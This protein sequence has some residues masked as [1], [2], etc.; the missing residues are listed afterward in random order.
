MDGRAGP[1]RSLKPSTGSR[2]THTDR[3]LAGI[4]ARL[5]LHF[6][7][8][9]DLS[10]SARA[11]MAADWLEDLRE[12]GPAAVAHACRDWRRQPGARRPL[13][14]DIRKLC[15]EAQTAQRERLAHASYSDGDGYA[16][17][18]GW[19]S[20]AERRE[21]IRKDEAVREGRYE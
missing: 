1:Q 18:V 5:L 6:W 2:D 13:P 9:G 3:E 21:A 16:R 11:A 20:E 12:F 4:I 19:A 14:G 8:P 7:A 17:S 15:I 10:D